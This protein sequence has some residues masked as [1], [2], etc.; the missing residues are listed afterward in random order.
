MFTSKLD[1]DGGGGCQGEQE[2][3]GSG[4]TGV[5]QVQECGITG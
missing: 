4:G 5:L 3:R 2:L 1:H